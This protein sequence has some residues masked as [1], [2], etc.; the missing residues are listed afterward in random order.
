MK[1][2]KAWKK[3]GEGGRGK[4][5][6]QKDWRALLER[7]AGANERERERE[8]TREGNNDRGG[9]LNAPEIDE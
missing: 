8:R 5:N 2:L 9:L 4:K 3:K 7:P 1:A 6:K